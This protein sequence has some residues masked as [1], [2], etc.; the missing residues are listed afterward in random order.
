[1]GMI[2]INVAIP[3]PVGFHS[4]GGWK[5]SL[6]GD[7]SMYG[8]EG[9]RFYTRPKVVTTRWPDPA[10]SVVDLGFPHTARRP[11]LQGRGSRPTRAAGAPAAASG[12]SPTP[13]AASSTRS[14]H[15][16]SPQGGSASCAAGAIR[17]GVPRWRGCD[18]DR[19]PRYGRRGRAGR[20]QGRL[21]R[22]AR[23]GPRRGEGNR[24]S[25]HCSRV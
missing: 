24:V 18:A 21:V 5:A 19:W 22:E 6:F 16:W 14:F 2:G 25:I 13:L 8:P 9:V 1:M 11:T 17:P 3:V 10:T 15:S 12:K 23:D 7:S 20:E 4:F